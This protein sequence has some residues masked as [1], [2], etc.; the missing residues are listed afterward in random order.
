MNS[1]KEEMVSAA[2][3]AIKHIFNIVPNERALILTD[4]NTQNIAFAFNEALN[5]SGRTVAFGNN[6][7][8]PGGGKNKSKI[9]RDYLFYRPTINIKY[10]NG[11]E[12]IVIRDGVII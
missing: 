6:E 12:N 9:H 3:G 2:S 11:T 4:T 5:I 10:K 1:K 7:D 8:F